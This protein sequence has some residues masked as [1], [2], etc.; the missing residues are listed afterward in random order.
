[1]FRKSLKRSSSLVML[2][3]SLLGTSLYAM[4]GDELSHFT[5]TRPYNQFWNDALPTL[6]PESVKAS[7]QLNPDEL[8]EIE[9]FFTPEIIKIA[10]DKKIF[11][12]ILERILR[13][14]DS[15]SIMKHVS[16]RCTEVNFVN[17]Y[18]GPV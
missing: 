15:R 13:R 14:V 3:L 5:S 18:T 10:H 9:E 6:S 12:Q 17:H 11:S 8:R 7:R 1:M 2:S 4:E 16:H